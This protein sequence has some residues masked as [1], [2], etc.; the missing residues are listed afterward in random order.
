VLS[1]GT[2]LGIRAGLVRGYSRAR[3]LFCRQTAKLRLSGRS[4]ALEPSRYCGVCGDQARRLPRALDT[5]SRHECSAKD[6][7]LAAMEPDLSMDFQQ[8]AQIGKGH[9]VS[10]VGT[11]AERPPLGPRCNRKLRGADRF[12]AFC[13][14]VERTDRLRMGLFGG[15]LGSGSVAP[16]TGHWWW[17]RNVASTGAGAEVSTRCVGPR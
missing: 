9:S 16:S 4:N 6:T 8:P 1:P 13:R 15:P 3:F 7:P 5:S 11:R 17:P 2:S 10:R 12:F 14:W